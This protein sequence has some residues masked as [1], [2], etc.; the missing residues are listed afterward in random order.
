MSLKEHVDCWFQQ[1]EY[2][3]IENQMDKTIEAVNAERKKFGRSYN[4]RR[5]SLRATKKRADVKSHSSVDAIAPE[6]IC[7]RG[8][9]ALLEHQ[10][11]RRRALR[12]R[13][14][15]SVLSEQDDQYYYGIYDD[16]SI[17]RSYF[18]ISRK[19]RL[20]AEIR[21]ILDRREIEDYILEDL[22]LSTLSSSVPELKNRFETLGTLSGRPESRR[23]RR[24]SNGQQPNPLNKSCGN[25]RLSA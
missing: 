18:T 11:R 24:A 21:A 14:L 1:Y 25:R 5:K 6:E 3:E 4:Y 22:D 12:S 17:A 20:R 19:C 23:R 9:E 7:L 8:L 15:E 10:H 16:E 2:N 13:A